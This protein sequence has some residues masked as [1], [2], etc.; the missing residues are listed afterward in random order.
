MYSTKRWKFRTIVMNSMFSTLFHRNCII[1]NDFIF[2][3][4]SYFI[5]KFM[6][7]MRITLILNH[8]EFQNKANPG[9]EFFDFSFLSC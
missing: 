2:L 8:N 9:L 5:D 7:F 6:I 4:N 1:K 3:D